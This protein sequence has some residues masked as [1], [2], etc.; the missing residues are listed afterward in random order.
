MKT[1]IICLCENADVPLALWFH[2]T[3]FWC[4]QK[5]KKWVMAA[6]IGYGPFPRLGIML[7]MLFYNSLSPSFIS[8]VITNAISSIIT[9]LTINKWMHELDV[10]FCIILMKFWNLILFCIFFK[11][12]IIEIWCGSL[13]KN[14]KQWLLYQV[15]LISRL[16]K[17]SSIECDCY[18]KYN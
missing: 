15:Q 13:L 18:T 16:I 12:Y 10:V 1:K 11:L 3:L 6:F 17:P 4:L 7:K 5:V 9:K 14:K 2:V 8:H